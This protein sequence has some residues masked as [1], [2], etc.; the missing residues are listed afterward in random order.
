M[1]KDNLLRTQMNNRKEIGRAPFEV[2]KWQLSKAFEVLYI[3]T[4]TKRKWLSNIRV[5]DCLFGFDYFHKGY[6]I[7]TKFGLQKY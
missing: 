5:T 4:I 3:V 2:Q 1:T 6:R 7:C